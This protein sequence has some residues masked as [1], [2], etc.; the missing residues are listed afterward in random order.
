[1]YHN[2]ITELKRNFLSYVKGLSTPDLTSRL[3]MLMQLVMTNDG[4][5]TLPTP[6]NGAHYKKKELKE[7][8]T[9]YVGQHYSMACPILQYI[10][11]QL[12][13]ELAN[14][15]H[16]QAIHYRTIAD[17]TSA[18]INSEYLPAWIKFK[19]PWNLHKSVIEDFFDHI[20]WRQMAQG[21]ERAFRFK[22]IKASNG[23]VCATHYPD[24]SNNPPPS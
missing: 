8:F 4:F 20:S 15:G 21:A 24:K 13:A 1:M 18:F 17:Q 23:S 11:T 3:A 7:L 19:D 5:L 16:S 2:Q 10:Y 6:W 14:N 9:L 22:G 12:H